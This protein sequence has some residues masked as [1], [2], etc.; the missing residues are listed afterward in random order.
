LF[1]AD[2]EVADESHEYRGDA[3]R[4]WMDDA[5]AKYSPLQAE[6]TSWELNG[7]E[8]VVTAQVSGTFPGSPVQLRYAFN[9]RND[10]I[11]TLKIY[12]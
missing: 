6:V 3:I 8:Y 2:A 1:S 11:A 7:S 12:P 5:I 9:L 4:A 10:Q